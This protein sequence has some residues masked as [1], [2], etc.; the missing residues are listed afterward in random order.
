MH[1]LGFIIGTTADCVARSRATGKK[2]KRIGSAAAVLLALLPIAGLIYTWL[3]GLRGT[4]STTPVVETNDDRPEH[5]PP[6]TDPNAPVGVYIQSLSSEVVPG[7][8]CTRLREL[9]LGL[10]CVIKSATNPELSTD[11][12]LCRNERMNTAWCAGAGRLSQPLRGKAQPIPP[13]PQTKSGYMHGD[14]TVVKELAAQN[15]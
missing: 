3:M 1:V 10:E 2:A 5:S 4:T 15:Q 7:K 11:S 6:P 13:V 14:I 8:Q 9:S 12:G